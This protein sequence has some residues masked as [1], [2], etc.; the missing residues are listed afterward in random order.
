MKNHFKFIKC[1][2][3][4]TL[5]TLVI[6]LLAPMYTYAQEDIMAITR[7]NGYEV[8]DFYRPKAAMVI[9]A[10][11]GS[12]VWEENP[13]TVL[14]FASLAKLMTAYLVLEAIEQGKYT[15]DTT[16]TATESDAAISQIYELSNSTIIAGVAYPVRELLTMSMV[17]SSNVATVMLANLTSTNDEAAFIQMMNT[18]AAELGM[19][20]TIF[21]NAAG[22][23]AASFNGYYLPEGIDPNADNQS[24]ARDLAV[25]S[26]YLLTKYPTIL[27][28]TSQT[29][30]TVMAGT[31]YEEVLTNHNYS[32]PG[33]DYGYES[34]TGLKTG[35]SPEAGFNYIATAQQGE[36]QL[37]EVIL[38]VG[39]WTDQ[40][41]EYE[42][43][44]FGNALFTYSFANYEYKKLFN[45][46]TLTLNQKDIELEQD[47][48]GFVSKSAPPTF[49]IEENQLLIDNGLSHV[50]ESIPRQTVAIKEKEEL[51]ETTDSEAK[52]D[53]FILQKFKNGFTNYL[54]SLVL[55]LSGFLLRFVAK[56]TKRKSRGRHANPSSSGGF[57]AIIGILAV[58]GGFAFAFY[59]WFQ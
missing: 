28:F 29:T 53:S 1:T 46:G 16:V 47:V 20:N 18:K 50:S 45:K 17:A 22:A 42:R 59:T 55:I 24:T 44:K 48:Y 9:D 6:S 15:L 56:K 4:F 36:T 5:I 2:A 14:S 7:N 26:Y 3:L 12:V 58:V 35:S 8:D 32:L 51:P 39:D 10:R 34:V 52:K 49:Q 19:A 54:I 37:I 40:N 11:T 27:A 13:D 41:G 30:A 31:A 25:L 21:Y 38:G 33:L 23:E 57:L 43:H